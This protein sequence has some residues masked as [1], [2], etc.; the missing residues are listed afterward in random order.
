MKK[1]LL[2]LVWWPL[3]AWPQAPMSLR[4]AVQM[5]LN[6]NMAPSHRRLSSSIRNR[7]REGPRAAFVL[8]PSAGSR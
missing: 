1:T 3:I 6:T 7:G 8:V 5:A 4:D 2:V